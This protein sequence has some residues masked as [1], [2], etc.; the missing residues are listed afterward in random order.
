M[1][2]CVVSVCGYVVCVR[3]CVRASASDCAREACVCLC[4][5]PLDHSPSLTHDPPEP[6]LSLHSPYSNS[7]D[8]SPSLTHY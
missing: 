3:A 6:P 7:L 5:C 2:V 4:M 8:H 1:C